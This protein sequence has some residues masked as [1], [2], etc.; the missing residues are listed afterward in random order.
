MMQTRY[1]LARQYVA[2]K[3]VL[4]VACGSGYGLGYLASDAKIAV[5]GD[6]DLTNCRRTKGKYPNRSN[7][8]VINL[9]AEHLPFQKDSFDVLILFE[10][11]YYIRDALRFFAEARRVLRPGGTLALSSV[12]CIWG[13]FNPSPFST[14]YF[15]A[16]EIAL[17]LSD[18][19]FE[20]RILAGF[21]EET[22]HS[23]LVKAAVRKLAISLALIPKS[24]K[25]K[26]FLKRVFYGKLTPIPDELADGVGQVEPLSDVQKLG[27][28]RPYRMLYAIGIVA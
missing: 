5:G 6:I 18:A 19:G 2:G 16:A 9:D 15:T 3:E 28:L 8:A 10:A 17:A 27:D 7:M 4:E 21:P 25:G 22:N 11:L 1:H 12:N 13:G 23:H 14:R 26:Q 24:M 20:T